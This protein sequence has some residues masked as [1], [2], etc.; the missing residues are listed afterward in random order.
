V[1]DGEPKARRCAVV[2]DIDSKPF[3]ADDFGKALDH[4][5]DVVERVAE[6][7][8]RRHVGLTEPRKVWRDNMKSVG[9]PRD[10]VSEHVAGTWEAVQQ[11]QPRRIGWPRLAIENLETIDIGRAVFDG[12][13]GTLL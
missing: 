13:H 5:R 12:R 7:F 4:A 6:F 3:E 8:S 11:Q 9:E 10:Q 1:A 2:K